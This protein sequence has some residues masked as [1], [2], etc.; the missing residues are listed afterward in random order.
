[1]LRVTLR[2]YGT[3]A[4]HACHTFTRLRPRRQRQRQRQRQRR[5]EVIRG[6]GFMPTNLELHNMASELHI[7]GRCSLNVSLLNASYAH[8]QRADFERLLC[9]TS[10]SCL[11][12]MPRFWPRA[13]YATRC[14]ADDAMLLAV[15]ITR[16][17]ADDAMLLAVV[18]TRCTVDDAMLLAVVIT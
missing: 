15:V 17:T 4:Q 1:M 16:C 5:F 18:I 7:E 10:K 12:Y 8:L 13:F 9:F 2:A 14:T 3:P 6:L 11:W